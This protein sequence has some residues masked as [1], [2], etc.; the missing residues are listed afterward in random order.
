MNGIVKSLSILTVAW[1]GWAAMVSLSE[2]APLRAGASRVEITPQE[3]PVIQNGGFLEAT[4]DR[5]ADPLWA[6]CLI[7]DAGDRPLAMIV[8]DSCMMPREF[9]DDVKAR[10]AASTGIATDRILLS[11]THTHTAPSVMDFCLGSR[12]D[13]R[14][15]QYLPDRI[16]AAVVAA[17]AQLQEAEVGWGRVDAGQYTNCRR[18]ITQPDKMLTDPFGEVTVRANM[19][20]GYQNLN[21]VGPS[22]PTDPWLTVLSVRTKS[23]LP[24]ALLA[25]F[26]MHYF[27]GHPGLSSDYCGR[28]AYQIE[29]QLGGGQESFVAIMSQGTSG[30]LWWGNYAGSKESDQR[31]LEGYVLGLVEQTK[32]AIEHLRYVSDAPLQMS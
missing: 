20:P 30:D 5:I 31:D 17:Q 28:Y 29:Q 21:F 13:Q 6:R 11:A 12:A 26:S 7:L 32:A 4:V 23:G 15:T 8:V 10:I 25:N 9:C 24:L 27:G 18:W 16:V 1:A 22:G 3:L 19:H 14:Y 2:A